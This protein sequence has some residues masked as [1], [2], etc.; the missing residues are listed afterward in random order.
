M[1]A[2]LVTQASKR[3]R[4]LDALAD[5]AVWTY[6][7][8]VGMCVGRAWWWYLTVPDLIAHVGLVGMIHH[9]VIAAGWTLVAA[10][11]VG[12]PLAGRRGTDLRR[13]AVALAVGMSLAVGV[14]AAFATSTLS[15][16]HAV[17]H[18]TIA[19]LLVAAQGKVSPRAAV[20]DRHKG[21]A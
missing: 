1:E 7:I 10:V 16:Q 5:P 6:T 8:V 12:S 18:I 4:V 9:D 17:S 20:P 11:I 19:L 13:W 3:N 14:S 15:H 2:L 21:G